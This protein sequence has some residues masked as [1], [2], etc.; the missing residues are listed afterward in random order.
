MIFLSKSQYR[1]QFSRLRKLSAF[2][3]R[4]IRQGWRFYIAVLACCTLIMALMLSAVT[5]AAGRLY[6]KRCLMDSIG[7]DMDQVMH[8]EY[9]KNDE[10]PE[11][12]ETLAQFRAHIAALP[13]VLNIGQFDATGV[14]FTELRK[15][16]QYQDRNADFVAGTRYETV[17]DIARIVRID[18]CLL[19]LFDIG[20]TEYPKL[21][22]GYLPIYASDVFRD[23]LP[24]GMQLT[25]AGTGDV[26]EVAGYLQGDAQ[27][28]NEN[29][30]IRLP[31]D[32]LKGRFIVPWSEKCR[33]D[34]LLQ[35]SA[36]HNTYIQIAESSDREY[37]KQDIHTDSL[38]RG[39][40]AVADTLAAEYAA[41][42]TETRDAARVSLRLAAMLAIFAIL[43]P[44][45]L[46][47]IRLHRKRKGKGASASAPAGNVS[48]A[49]SIA[50][51]TGMLILPSALLAWAIQRIMLAHTT[52][53]FANAMRIAQVRYLLP[54]C[55]A[56]GFL[57]W[58]IAIPI[59]LFHFSGR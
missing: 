44:A 51:E 2:Y 42:D 11:F 10:A 26:Y 38:Q 6:Q 54:A 21:E 53:L 4:E 48:T 14:Y 29:D 49:A 13:G 17:P 31:L 56:F 16:P 46:C 19:P 34:I 7:F 52:G 36:L 25:D 58:I 1:R 57:P 27:W 59:R 5:D 43:V 47:A 22:S 35:L 24:L 33:G 50:M 55:I 9:R 15:M 18:A 37:L 41:Y 40:E 23:M 45:A 12:A 28:A 3:T 39:F 20:I 8:L 30:L 32:S